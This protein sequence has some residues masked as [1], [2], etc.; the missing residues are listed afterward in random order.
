MSPLVHFLH[1]QLQ[2]IVSLIKSVFKHLSKLSLFIEVGIQGYHFH[3]MSY[4][5]KE[6][7]RCEEESE[8]KVIA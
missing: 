7:M 2:F 3:Q 5:L 8:L 1:Y 4:T 6:Q